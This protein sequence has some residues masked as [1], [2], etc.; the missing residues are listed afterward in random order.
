MFTPTFGVMQHLDLSDEE[1]AALIKAPFS[2]N[3]PLRR[4]LVPPSRCGMVAAEF[5]FCRSVISGSRGRSIGRDVMNRNTVA[6]FLLFGAGL[7]FAAPGIGANLIPMAAAQMPNICPPGQTFVIAQGKCVAAQPT[8]RCPEGQE[9]DAQTN[10]CVTARS[11]VRCP[12]GQEFD[13]RTNRCVTARSAVRCPEGQDF[14]AQ[15]NRCVTARSAVRCPGGQ[16]FDAQ[17]NRCVT[18]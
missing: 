17:T 11:A 3:A 7:L 15:T 10:R 2:F 16:E 9:F 12:E 8:V 14:D 5:G 6:L 18:R 4:G 1:A 13:A